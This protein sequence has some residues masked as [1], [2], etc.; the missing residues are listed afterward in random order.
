MTKP[1]SDW[2]GIDVSKAEIVLDDG[3]AITCLPNQT[4]AIRAWLRGLPGPGRI[5]IEATGNHHRKVL[6]LAH[7]AGHRLFVIDG[8]RLSR[9][10]DSIGGRAK[11]DQSDA[12]LLRRYLQREHTELRPWTPPPPSY[13]AIQR[14]LRRRA[15]LVQVR[16]LLRQSLADLPELRRQSDTLIDRL[17]RLIV[18]LEHRLQQLALQ[19][20]LPTRPLTRVEGIGPLTATALAN[21]YQRGPFSSSDAFIAFLGLDVRVRDSGKSRGR[22]KLTKQGDPELRRL[23][24]NAAMAASRSER[25]KPVYA[26]YL[27]RGL[28]RIQSLV[29]LARKLARIAFALLKTGIPYQSRP[30]GGACLAT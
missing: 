29:I 7:A 28:S 3:Q 20:E 12:Q 17:G 6:D 10:R 21:T 26:G 23:L 30:A 13:D 27:S 22:R 14:L 5:A 25:W 24:F 16:T 19:V 18:Q 8:L 4:T 11:T 15:K 1:V 9:Y 2:I